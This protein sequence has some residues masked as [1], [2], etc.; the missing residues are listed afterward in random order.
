M[1]VLFISDGAENMENAVY[2]YGGL[3]ES[4]CGLPCNIKAYK[5][6]DRNVIEVSSD[7]CF[8]RI[9]KAE[10]AD[11]IADVIAVNYKYDFFR[12][13][14]KPYGLT[15]TENRILLAAVVSADIDDDREYI[16]QCISTEDEFPVDGLFNFRLKALKSKWR[17][18]SLY[19][20]KTFDAERLK[21]FIAFIL[22]EKK[23]KR[24]F[25]K[26]GNVY[27][28]HY[29]KLNRAFLSGEDAGDEKLLTEILLSGAGEAELLSPV[30]AE[31]EEFLTEYYGNKIIFSDGCFKS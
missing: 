7:D 3:T 10:A 20:P 1:N 15:D 30:R 28:C 2:L 13:L 23:N 31:E 22:E 6:T 4:L 29:K 11:K 25:V 16:K 5:Q 27:D 14:C 12:S 24:V 8:W 18:I 9:V 17:D 19:L 26:N 21:D